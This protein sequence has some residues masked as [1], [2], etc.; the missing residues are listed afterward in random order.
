MKHILG[1]LGSKASLLVTKHQ[2][3]PFMQMR[4]YEFT[5]QCRS[6]LSYKVEGILSPRGQ[7]YI[8]DNAAFLHLA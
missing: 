5:L 4:G 6:M 7:Y 2:V 1:F 8:V 3:D